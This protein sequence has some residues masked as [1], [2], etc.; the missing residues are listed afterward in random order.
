MKGKEVSQR[1]Q[2]GV[3][4]SMRLREGPVNLCLKVPRPETGPGL[5]LSRSQVRCTPGSEHPVCG[6]WS[7][8]RSFCSFVETKRDFI[9]HAQ[10]R[11]GQSR[12]TGGES[13]IR[14]QRKYCV[15]EASVAVRVGPARKHQTPRLGLTRNDKRSYQFINVSTP[16]CDTTNFV[17]RLDTLLALAFSC[18]VVFI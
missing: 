17:Y 9:P 4:V 13:T 14:P 16:V 1:E 2:A 12:W 18:S 11:R 3:Q 15:R 8:D 10:Y 7:H 5:K 6:V